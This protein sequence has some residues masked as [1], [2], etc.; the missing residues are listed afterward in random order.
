MTLIVSG[1]NAAAT[2]E[3][4]TDTGLLMM[5]TSMMIVPLILIVIS[6]IIHDKKYKIDKNMYDKIIKDLTKRGE[7]SS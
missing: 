4:V 6:Y 5:K 1:I 3:D 2:P 7:I